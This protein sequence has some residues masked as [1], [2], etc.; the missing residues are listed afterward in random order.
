M[1]RLSTASNFVFG[2]RRLQL[3]PKLP[4]LVPTG[5]RDAPATVRC[6]EASLSTLPEVRSSRGCQPLSKMHSY[7]DCC[8]KR[9]IRMTRTKPLGNRDKFTI[10]VAYT[11]RKDSKVVSP[12][13]IATIEYMIRQGTKQLEIYE[14]P[15]LRDC[16]LTDAMAE[17]ARE[18]QNTIAAM[19]RGSTRPDAALAPTT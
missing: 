5:W 10:F 18:N 16:F 4:T 2:A 19:Q 15:A 13:D 3:L 11:F 9:A 14:N 6:A 7:T 8:K 1:R 17:W 12:R